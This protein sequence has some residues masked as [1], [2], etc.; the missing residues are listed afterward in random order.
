M[1]DWLLNLP[2]PWMAVI[3][4]A[5]TYL[6]AAGIYWVVTSLAVNDRA[7]ALKEVSPLQSPIYGR[8]FRRT[9]TQSFTTPCRSRLRKSDRRPGHVRFV[10][11]A[12]IVWRELS[13]AHP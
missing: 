2:V 11:K 13:S 10:P 1:G 5:G 9:G 6:F 3:V 8:N 12:D 7:R 4:F